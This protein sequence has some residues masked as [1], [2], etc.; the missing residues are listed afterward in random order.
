MR[1][2]HFHRDPDWQFQGIFALYKCRCGTRRTRWVNRKMSGPLPDGFPSLRDRHG[3]TL[4]D[5][6]WVKP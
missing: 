3:M 5:S 2:P 4:T 1:H 6:G